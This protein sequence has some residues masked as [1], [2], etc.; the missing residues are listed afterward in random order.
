M[1]RFHREQG[2][3]ILQVEKASHQHLSIRTMPVKITESVVAIGTSRSEILGGTVS[4]GPVSAF[5][6]NAYALED[7]QADVDNHG[8]N[9]GGALLDNHG[10]VVGVTYA[11]IGGS[12][13]F[14][15]G[16]N[17][18]IRIT[19]TEC[20]SNRPAPRTGLLRS[21][22][23]APLTRPGLKTTSCAHIG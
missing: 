20:P 11:G 12:D 22:V 3:A 23:Y 2:V 5:R 16:L 7:V 14:L 13:G 17:L 8:G 9:S 19:K 15:T 18:F 6:S 21:R 1:I 10:N 4:K